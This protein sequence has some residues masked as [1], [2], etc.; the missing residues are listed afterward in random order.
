MPT[1]KLKTIDAQTLMNKE[2]DDIQFVVDGFLPQGLQILAGKAKIGKS[3]LILSLCLSVASGNEFWNRKTKQGTVLYMC[4]EDSENRLQSRL[5]ELTDKPPEKLYFATIVKS[6]VDGLAE[7]IEQFIID[8]PDTVLIVIDTLQKV[9]NGG[10]NANPYASDYDDIG[11]LKEIADKYSIAM[12]VV[13]HLR[14]QFDSDP[15]SMVSGTTGL[16]G[17]SD[18]SYVLLKEPDGTAK[19][20]IRGRDIEEQ[21]F[22]LKFDSEDLTWIYISSD[23]PSDEML[24]RDPFIPLLLDFLVKEKSFDGTAQELVDQLKLFCG[25]EIKANVLS[26]KLQQFKTQL[27]DKRI[28]Y[29]KKRTGDK[30]TLSLSVNTNDDNDG[31]DGITG[32]S[33]KSS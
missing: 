3:W 30:R 19:L 33:D 12:I 21:V 9:R 17:A 1:E 26:R 10:N 25:T 16:V 14:K 24:N 5:E 11:Q 23:T 7:Q 2:L 31:N 20:H 22:T 13:Q 8:H 29:S 18:G 32:S 28:C 6:L 15:H 4:L 27:A